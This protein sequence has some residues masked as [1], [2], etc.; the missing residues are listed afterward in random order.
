MQE[1]KAQRFDFLPLTLS[2]ETLGGKATPVMR[3]GTSLPATRAHTFS[4]AADNQKS[5]Q[6]VV[7]LGERPLARSNLPIGSVLLEGIPLA[8]RG[9]P[10]IRVSFEVDSLCNVKVGAI[11]VKSSNRIDARFESAA[12]KLTSDVIQRLL[13]DA[14]NNRLEDRARSVIAR[15][16][17]QVGRDQEQ[18][19][20]TETTKKTDK[21]IADLGMALMEQNRLLIERTTAEL[22]WLL[23]ERTYSDPALT[24]LFDIFN[25]FYRSKPAKKTTQCQKEPA[26]ADST[27]VKSQYSNSVSNTVTSTALVQNF[28]ESIDPQLELKRLGAWEAL[29]SN[30]S[31]GPSQAAH[32]MREVL[33]QLLDKLAPINEVLRAPWYRRPIADT[34]VTRAMRVRYALS[35]KASETSESTLRLIETLS[36]TVDSAYAKLSAESHS[37]KLVKR[38]EVRSCLVAC[39]AIIGLIQSQRRT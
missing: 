31:D 37:D 4:T 1:R 34:T 28:L 7:F 9:Q 15:A 27:P 38:S 32:S 35:G 18:G 33:R 16:E 21:V 19:L 6:I 3:R 36:A 39:E 25:G 29:E 13:Q 2:I 8:P 17:Q 11:E 12:S 30:N 26:S 5:V 20:A 23:F 24:N 22:E 14:E 10:Q